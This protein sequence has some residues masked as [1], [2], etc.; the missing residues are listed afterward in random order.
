MQLEVARYRGVGGGAHH[1]LAG[2][3]IAVAHQRK[4]QPRGFGC[5]FGLRPLGAW[6][7]PEF[8]LGESGT[9]GTAGIVRLTDTCF[10]R[11]FYRNQ[12]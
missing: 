3:E 2:F 1:W 5:G 12:G 9:G 6:I 10:S 7:D 11:G 8:E 4:R